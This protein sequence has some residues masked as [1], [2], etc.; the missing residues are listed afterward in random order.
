MVVWFI[1][2]KLELMRQ[3]QNFESEIYPKKRFLSQGCNV[4]WESLKGS[5]YCESPLRRL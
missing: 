3:F 2:K 5:P 1:L 4:R